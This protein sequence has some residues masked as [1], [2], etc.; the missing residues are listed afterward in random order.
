MVIN[1]F[2][3]FPSYLTQFTVSLV[4]DYLKLFD[5]YFPAGELFKWISG[6]SL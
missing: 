2:T 6:K 4:V 1:T 3:S 5:F